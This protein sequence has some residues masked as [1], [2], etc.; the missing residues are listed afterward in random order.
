MQTSM[1]HYVLSSLC[2][3]TVPVAM[4]SRCSAL[5]SNSPA[6]SWAED[7]HSPQHAIRRFA[8][9]TTLPKCLWKWAGPSDH[10]WI[11]A[12][13]VWRPLK[14]SLYRLHLVLK[15]KPIYSIY[16]PKYRPIVNVLAM[17]DI[18]LVR[19]RVNF[20]VLLTSVSLVLG[21]LPSTQ[22]ASKNTCWKK[23]CVGLKVGFDAGKHSL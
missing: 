7:W 13:S 5:L 10:L 11:R 8:Q 22:K 14:E 23:D 21:T 6:S 2:L 3:I 9:H 20:N 4:E 15:N 18:I 1:A 19:S 12:L 17:L 16:F